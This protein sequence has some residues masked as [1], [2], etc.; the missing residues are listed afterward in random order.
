MPMRMSESEVAAAARL[1]EPKTAQEVLFWA[2]GR[3]ESKAA[4]A[5]SFGA[6]D[7]VL[8]D[9]LSKLGK[10][11]RIFTLDT[12]RLPQETYDVIDAV[13]VKYGLPTEVYFPSAEAVEEMVSR[14]GFNL[15]YHAI[16]LRML[17]C[18]T[19][20]VEPL[21]R[22][23]SG[24]DAWMTGLRREQAS[25]RAFIAKVEVDHANG[26]LVKVNPLADWTSEQVWTYIRAN[27]VPYNAIFDQGYTSIGCAP[28]TR[29]TLP[30]EDPRLGR[31]WWEQGS[32]R[33]CGLHH[34][35]VTAGQAAAEAAKE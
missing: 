23:L 19:R 21:R 2:L 22:A 9:M 20:K 5:S 8:I 33:E 13:R 25:T 18:Q 31:W 6:E 30:G 15:F 24:L 14:H 35:F 26:G 7:V 27:K 1:L 3:F 32:A 12:G 29:P 4:L 34:R 16:E 10:P 28:C 11:A 17:C